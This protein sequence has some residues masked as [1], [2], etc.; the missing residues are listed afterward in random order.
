MTTTSADRS[1][2]PLVKKI[3]VRC[4]IAEAFKYFTVDFSKWWP[5]DTHS[6]T[7]MSTKGRRRPRSCVFETFVGGRIIECADDTEQ[8]LWGTV[9]DWDPPTRVT[10]TWHPGRRPETAQTVVVS[11]RVVPEG[12]EVVLIHSGWEKLA[13]E[14]A[15]SRASYDNGWESVF[16]GAYGGYVDRH[17]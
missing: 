7:A 10:F 4:G 3:Q 1:I 5:L 11:F 2:E 14:A 13:E 6:C 15:R 12:T 9:V 17:R 8:H 16:R